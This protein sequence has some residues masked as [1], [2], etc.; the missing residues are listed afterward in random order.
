MKNKLELEDIESVIVKEQYVKVGEKTTVGVLTLIN[1]FEVVG[2]SACVDPTNYDHEIGCSYARKRAL[3][4]VWELEGYNLQ[5]S[6]FD[7]SNHK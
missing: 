2:V 4:K 5:R 1:G 3:D 6:L 7:F